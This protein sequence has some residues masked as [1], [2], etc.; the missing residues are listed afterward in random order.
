MMRSGRAF[1]KLGSVSLPISMGTQVGFKQVSLLNVTL[2]LIM[3]IITNGI[4]LFFLLPSSTGSDFSAS[5]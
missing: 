2:D 5:R 3:L 4:I 1:L